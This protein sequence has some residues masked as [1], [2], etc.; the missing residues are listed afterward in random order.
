MK[1][2]GAGGNLG[3]SYILIRYIYDKIRDPESAMSRVTQ[4]VQATGTASS[5]T[6]F[7]WTQLVLGI[8]CMAS[9]ANLQY[10]WTLFVLPIQHQFGWT[11]AEIQVA[12]TIF[13]L[14]ETWLV[15]FEGYIVDRI[16]P[17][18]MVMAGGV[19]TFL[20]WFI[21][22]HHAVDVLRRRCGRRLCRRRRLWDLCGQRIKMVSRQ[23]WLMR[24][25]RRRGDHN[26]ADSID[27]PK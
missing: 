16:G 15:P 9:V 1:T 8:I 26:R 25:P 10:G 4:S 2:A 24:R 14:C 13:I 6:R 18:W 21:N 7:R 3:R 20:A 27:D 17:R 23:A 19:G 12:F 22:S 11:K 5:F